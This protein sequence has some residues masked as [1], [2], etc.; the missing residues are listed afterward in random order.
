MIMHATLGPSGIETPISWVQYGR[1][2][3][4]RLG[5]GSNHI[6]PGFATQG[7]QLSR[8]VNQIVATLNGLPLT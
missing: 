4:V 8:P 7:G 6:T 3:A 2:E 5:F 1:S